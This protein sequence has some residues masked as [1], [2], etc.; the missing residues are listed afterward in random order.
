MPALVKMTDNIWFYREYISDIV[1]NGKQYSIFYNPETEEILIHESSYVDG[2]LRCKNPAIDHNALQ[3][4]LK[5]IYSVPTN[6][7]FL[8]F[9]KFS[10]EF[11]GK[12]INKISNLEPFLKNLVLNEKEK[13]DLYKKAK[14]NKKGRP[15]KSYLME[16]ALWAILNRK[17]R[18]EDSLLI[19]RTYEK[20]KEE[21]SNLKSFSTSI[22][23]NWEKIR[24]EH[25]DWQEENVTKNNDPLKTF[26]RKKLRKLKAVNKNKAQKKLTEIK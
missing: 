3:D 24:K 18:E 20:Y 15:S 12:D 22:K 5:V 11:L 14:P 8:T 1:S 23:S 25:K 6:N 9:K 7:R 21:S 10:K 16:A 2:K 26:A 17:L 4:L 13:Q 19:S